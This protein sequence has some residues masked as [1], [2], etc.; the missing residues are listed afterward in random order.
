MCGGT[1]ISRWAKAKKTLGYY[2]RRKKSFDLEFTSGSITRQVIE[3]KAAVHEC[4]TCGH[5][6]SRIGTK[7][8]QNTF[9]V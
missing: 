4:R 3:F 8:R 1:E 5:V 2:S 6:L 7:G 9:T